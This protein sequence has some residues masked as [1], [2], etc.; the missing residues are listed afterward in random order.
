AYTLFDSG[1]KMDAISP[2]F[3]CAVHIPI[4]QLENPVVLQMGMKGTRSQIL[5]GTNVDVEIN[6]HVEK[7]Y[8]DVINI[9]RYDA[10][11]S[12]TSHSHPLPCT[13]PPAHFPQQLPLPVRSHERQVTIGQPTGCTSIHS[14]YSA[15]S[16]MAMQPPPLVSRTA[17][18]GFPGTHSCNMNHRIPLKDPNKKFRE[19]TPR[20]PAALQKALATKID[21]YVKAGWW[22]PMS[23]EQ[24]CPLL[25]ICK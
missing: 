22:Y 1:A 3:V 20:C 5:F 12:P 21:R 13:G 6:G 11:F 7:H 18:V 16:L 2:D 10:I 15:L 14:S 8:F 17:Q 19:N 23:S 24:A 25:C 4:L 9:D